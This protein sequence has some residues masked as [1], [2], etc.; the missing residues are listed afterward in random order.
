[1]GHLV[2]H[3]RSNNG[4]RC[5]DQGRTG[6]EGAEEHLDLNDDNDASPGAPQNPEFRAE[7]SDG[8]GGHLIETQFFEAGERL[9]PAP[10]LENPN[11]SKSATDTH[12][13]NYYKLEEE[14]AR[15]TQ[16]DPATGLPKAQVSA[17][18]RVSTQPT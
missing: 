7:N 1:M 10:M 16:K 9:N 8:N 4:R 3:T 17:R 18:I 5:P 15:L 14:W 13:D 12:R 2:E 11:Q 6:N